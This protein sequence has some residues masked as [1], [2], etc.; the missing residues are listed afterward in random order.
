MQSVTAPIVPCASL[1]AIEG[2]ILCIRSQRVI[3]DADLASLY[4]V[5]TKRL[6]EQV[7]RNADRFPSDFMFSLSTEEK[8]EVVANCDHLSKLKYAK[9]LPFVFTEHG[10]IQAAN[11]LG[12]PQ[13]IQM[14]VY[15]VRTFV[16]LRQMLVSDEAAAKRFNE[17]EAQLAAL[18]TGQENFEGKTERQFQQIFEIL[19]GLTTQPQSRKRP[20]GFILPDK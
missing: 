6:N 19:R 10:A 8:A 9:A 16:R 12:S 13:A 17:L 5:P 11:V 4:G 14:G 2:R 1:V 20:I 7:K 18:L 3:I 15:V